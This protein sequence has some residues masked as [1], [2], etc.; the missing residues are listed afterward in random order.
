MHKLKSLQRKLAYIRRFISILDGRCHPFH[1]LMN[2]DVPFIWDE[3]CTN[4]FKSIK[5]YLMNP[6]VLQV[7]VLGHPLILYT[8]AQEYSLGVLLAQENDKGKE[9]AIYYLSI[10]LNKAELNYSLIEKMS[11]ALMFAF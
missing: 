2:K 3:V 7:P 6:Q 11:L 4:T 5:K 9:V 10:T 1:R 8:T